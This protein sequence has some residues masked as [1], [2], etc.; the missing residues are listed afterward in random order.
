V[1][2]TTAPAT[3]PTGPRTTAPESAPS[4][5][6]PTRSCAV[7][8]AGASTAA[9]AAAMIVLFM[10]RP[11]RMSIS[12]NDAD[13]AAALWPEVHGDAATGVDASDAAQTQQGARES[14]Q[15]LAS[16]VGT[17]R[18]IFDAATR[19][20][21]SNRATRVFRTAGKIADRVTSVTPEGGCPALCFETARGFLPNSPPV[22]DLAAEAPQP[23]LRANDRR[24]FSVL[25]RRRTELA[26]PANGQDNW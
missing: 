13:I 7:A 2:P 20:A 19:G 1:K 25:S 10:R 8:A 11:P 12:A 23:R 21:G 18:A 4:A 6:S 24:H 3:A 17:V 5:A 26:A 16:Y 15:W 14:S 9:S 22:R